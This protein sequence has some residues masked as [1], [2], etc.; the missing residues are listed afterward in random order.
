MPS[1]YMVDLCFIRPQTA[2]PSPF[3]ELDVQMRTLFSSGASWFIDRKREEGLDIAIAQVN[4]LSSWSSEQEVISHMETRMQPESLEW[5]S[6]Y[7]IRV[8]PKENADTCCLK[9]R[10]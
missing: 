9:K 8:I 2:A 5:L 6:G 4:G 3:P 10:G 7:R 1:E